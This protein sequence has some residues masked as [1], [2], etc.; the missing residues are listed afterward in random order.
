MLKSKPPQNLMSMSFP[1]TQ[2]SWS[3][4]FQFFN[5][6]SHHI[7]PWIPVS[8]LKIWSANYWFFMVG[9][10]KCK[11]HIWD[12][13]K[14]FYFEVSIVKCTLWLFQKGYIVAERCGHWVDKLQIKLI[15]YLQYVHN[16]KMWSTFKGLLQSFSL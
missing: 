4:F 9:F 16:P 15:L 14:N 2:F 5:G 8:W 3:S 1:F 12:V 7:C 6:K 11:P 10:H 13:I